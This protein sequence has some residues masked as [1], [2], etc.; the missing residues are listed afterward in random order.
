MLLTN[1]FDPDP[2]VHQEASSLV[3]NGYNVTILCWD[4]DHKAVASETIDGIK[5]ERVYVRSSHGRGPGQIIFLFL[6][7]LKAYLKADSIGFDVI[8]CHDF[9]TLPLGY[10]LSRHNRTKLVYD[11]HESYVDMLTNVPG[12]LKRLIYTTENRLLKRVDLTITVGDILK[13]ALEQRG[14]KRACVVGNWKEPSKYSY[15]Q[16]LLD[17]EKRRF[18]ISD[19]QVVISF[20]ANLGRERK[21]PELVSAVMEMPQ[22]CLLVGGD[23]PAKETVARAAARYKNIHYLGY[24]HPERVPLFT[25]MSDIVFYG[26]EPTNSNSKFSSP[27]KLFEALAAGKA[28]LTGEFGEIGKIVRE[29][30]CGIFLRTYSQAELIRVFSK[31]TRANLAIYQDNSR[32]SA[33]RIYNW[34]RAEKTLMN[35]YK[36]VLNADFYE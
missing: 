5:I 15:P 14:A 2:R 19:R 35:H 8:H 16:T 4:R 24:V 18:G 25:A 28:I 10:F 7:W 17:T 1:A 33:E 12:W 27:N 36:L 6:F 26:Y 23:G 20:I 34:Q 13:D 30:E 31:L 11:A 22:V 29:H 32:K 3:R 21:V 9:D